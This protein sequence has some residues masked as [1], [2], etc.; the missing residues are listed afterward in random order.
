MNNNYQYFNKKQNCMKNTITIFKF[1]MIINKV[2]KKTN[3][4]KFN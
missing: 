4:F 3:N 1:M 2:Y